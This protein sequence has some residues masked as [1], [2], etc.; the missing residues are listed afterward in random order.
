M[1][2]YES[3][4]DAELV[5]LLRGGDE[6]AFE[7]IY[8]RY[9]SSLYRYAKRNI[10]I[11]EDC[12]EIIQEIFVSL[13]S[14]RE[15]L[16]HVSVLEAY[17]FRMVKYKIIRYFQHESVKRKYAEHYKLFEA[18][19]ESTDPN[20]KDS[21]GLRNMIER[22]LADLPERCRQAVK[23]RLIENLS[24]TDIAMRMNITKG[25]VEN[26]MVT[27]LNHFRLLARENGLSRSVF[28]EG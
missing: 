28:L 11:K 17:L 18:V 2:N 22:G 19:Y 3:L 25:T 14:R 15:N 24:N 7:A 6:R 8:R 23:L 16:D 12:Q 1:R 13:W 5:T 10:S 26:Y 20:E 27:A 9:V 21:S 4:G